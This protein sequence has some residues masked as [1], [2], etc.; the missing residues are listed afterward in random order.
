MN[1]T[2]KTCALDLIFGVRRTKV[3]TLDD[4]QVG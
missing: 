4:K 3:S 1:Y 2:L